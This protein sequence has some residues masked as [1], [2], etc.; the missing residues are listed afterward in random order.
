[1]NSKDEPLVAVKI[2][3]IIIKCLPSTISSGLNALAAVALKDFVSPSMRQNLGEHKQALLTK[4]FSVLFGVLCYSG[5]FVIR[6]SC[7][8]CHIA[9]SKSYDSH[10]YKS[11]KHSYGQKLTHGMSL[12]TSLA[13]LRWAP[14][15]QGWSQA[16]S[17]ACSWWGCSC[18]GSTTLELSLLSLDQFFSPGG[19]TKKKC[20]YFFWNVRYIQ[21]MFS[22]WIAVGGRVYKT[23]A[24]YTSITAPSAP[25]FESIFSLIFQLHLLKIW[26]LG[27]FSQIWKFDFISVN[28]KNTNWGFVLLAIWQ[29]FPAG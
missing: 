3:N 28:Q 7:L 12:G 13:C 24:P 17:L 26:L 9:L 23:A 6:Y 29:V 25:R 10:K 22:S 4:V 18:P 5:T 16:P 8:T 21:I 27:I 15:S 19:K 11:T 20:T 2:V 1:M 14:W